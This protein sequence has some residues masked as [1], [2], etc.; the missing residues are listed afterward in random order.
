MCLKFIS[1]IITTIGIVSTGLSYW[2]VVTLTNSFKNPITSMRENYIDTFSFTKCL[3]PYNTPKYLYIVGDGTLNLDT[4]PS[5]TREITS[6]DVIKLP[7]NLNFNLPSSTDFKF[8]LRTDESEFYLQMIIGISIL[9]LCFL[10]ICIGVILFM[11][12]LGEPK[13]NKNKK[14]DYKPINSLQIPMY[15]QQSYSV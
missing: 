11:K 9:S 10:F 15:N 14:S 6:Y 8:Y 5:I 1:I 7:S 2:Y 4:I 3:F 12:S 13:K